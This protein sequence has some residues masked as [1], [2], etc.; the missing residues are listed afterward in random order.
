LPRV[1]AIFPKRKPP[2]DVS[3]KPT[4]NFVKFFTRAVT[5]AQDYN[6]RDAKMRHAVGL[7]VRPAH[8]SAP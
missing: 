5:V 2:Q 6:Q 7:A 4:Q 1:K 3:G 8:F